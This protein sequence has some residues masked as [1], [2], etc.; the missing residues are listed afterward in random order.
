MKKLHLAMAAVAALSAGAAMAQSNATIYGRMNLS[1]E[2]QKDGGVSNTVMQN[3]ASRIGFKGTEDLGGGLKA[4]FV[5]EH[6]F[7]ADTGAASGAMWG[8]QSELNLSGGFGMVRLGRYT[9]EA[10]FATADYVSMHNHDTGTSADALYAYIDRDSNKLAYRTPDLGGL[11]LE[12]AVSLRENVGNYAYD[13]AANYDM[14]ALQLGAG[15]QKDGD[16]NQFALRALYTM[17]DFTFG[18]YVQR[19]EDV[20]GPG[21]RT[22]LRLSGMYTMGA[23]EFHLNVGRAGDYSDLDDSAATQYTLAYGYN[24]SK[25]TKAYAFYTKVSADSANPYVGDFSSFALGLR[26]NF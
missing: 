19:D 1:I 7:N 18:G 4:G 12:A 9:S 14:G 3:N 23:S 25:R 11:T 20:Y 17:G 16:A 6:G 2:R 13:V 21:S 5:L 22:N 15:Y 24:L 10:Y 8:R 26:H